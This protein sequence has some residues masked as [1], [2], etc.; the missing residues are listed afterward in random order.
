[1]TRSALSG[2]KI[3]EYANTISGAYCGKLLADLGADVIKIELPEGDPARRFG[4]FP[5]NIPDPEK[6]ALFL[7]LNTSKRGMTLDLK[8]PE[9]AE[10]FKRLIQWADILID[11]HFA[12]ELEGAGFG[13]NCLTQLHSGLIYTSITPYGRTGPRAHAKGDELTLIHAGGLGYLLPARSETTDKTPVKLGGFPM[14]YQGGISAALATLAAFFGRLKTGI[15]EFIDISIHDVVLNLIFPNAASTHYYDLSF[16]RVPDR[17]PAMGR[18]EVCDGYVILSAVD[19]HHFRAFRKLMGNPAWVDSDE[20]D[21]R[22]YR[23]N[24]LMDI[25][26]MINAWLKQQKMQDIFHEVAQKGIPI[27]PVNSAK[28]VME[29]KQYEARNYFVEVDHPKAGKYRYAGWPYKMTS[30]IARVSRPA[31]LLGQHNQEIL[32]ELRAIHAPVPVVAA[33]QGKL[34]L[35]GIRI[36][37]FSWVWAGPAATM[38]LAD[39]GAEVIKIEGHNRMDILRRTINWPLYEP[40]PKTCPINQGMSYNSVN[41]NKK[42]LTLDL[43][44][45]QGLALAL[46]LVKTCDMVIDNMRPGAMDKLGLGY[47]ALKAVKSDIIVAASSSHGLGGPLSNYLGF[48][49]V[50]HAVGGGT[51]ISGHPDDHPTHGSTGDADVLNA[52]TTAYAMMAALVHRAKTGE[53]Q[54]IDY[55]QSEGVSSVIGEILLGY[56]MTGEIPR[57]TGNAHPIFAPHNVYRCWGVDRWV[58]LEIHTDEEFKT[59]ASLMNQPEMTD[60]ERFSTMKSRKEH[61]KE[62]DAVIEKW[63]RQRDRDWMV[64]ELM[65]AGL[66]VAPCRDAADIYA[67]RHIQKRGSLSMIDHP[68]MGKLKLMGPPW[69]FSSFKKPNQHAPLLGEH[70]RYVLEGI[71]GLNED[72]MEALR[73]EDIIL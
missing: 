57:R 2:I 70:N 59:L 56:Q 28:D 7:Y 73:K 36:L 12:S 26:P 51:Y 10:T 35:E 38:R 14:Q 53:G 52:V 4:P 43:T 54:F 45:P 30:S 6:S 41:Q 20:W 64:N 32:K 9:D 11:D 5:E 63:T 55:S 48:A 61:E 18:T 19:D 27:G 50:H 3:V 16:H 39:L 65:Q 24:H 29:S 72:Q 68:E 44:N 47:E 34:P 60:H 66:Y 49:T 71:L 69:Q 23:T 13:W 58:A 15:G 67:D 46:K 31:P 62:L 1:M 17:P 33:V 25:A 37:D 42:G 8:K 21:N 40:T 22:S